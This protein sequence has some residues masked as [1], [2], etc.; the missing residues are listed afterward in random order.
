MNR[1]V[2]RRASLCL[3]LLTPLFVASCTSTDTHRLPAGNTSQNCADC[4]YFH[5]KAWFFTPTH[6]D[7]MEAV[8]QSLPENSPFYKVKNT[9]HL[10]FR[11]DAEMMNIQQTISQSYYSAVP[12]FFLKQG[13]LDLIIDTSSVTTPGQPIPISVGGPSGEFNAVLTPGVVSGKS[14]VRMVSFDISANLPPGGSAAPSN[15]LY[16]TGRFFLRNEEAGLNIQQVN[17]KYLVCLVRA[18]FSD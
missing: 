9:R 7:G 12:T 18:N 3:A 2:F 13:K 14:P 5:V 16:N 17:G 11:D 10:M 6:A 1:T 8:L 15:E 4:V